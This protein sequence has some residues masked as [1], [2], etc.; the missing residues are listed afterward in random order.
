MLQETLNSKSKM[1]YKK[2]KMKMKIQMNV[3]S[4]SNKWINSKKKGNIF[5]QKKIIS[6]TQWKQNLITKKMMNKNNLMFQKDM[7]QTMIKSMIELILRL[8]KDLFLS[9]IELILR[10]M[11]NI[12]LSMI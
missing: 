12:F 5:Y 3:K 10:S 8:M 1:E 7:I 9:M 11:K 2:M 4:S 6:I